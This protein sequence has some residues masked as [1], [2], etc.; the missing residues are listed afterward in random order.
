MSK[1]G[2]IKRVRNVIR[3]GW[4]VIRRAGRPSAALLTQPP[5]DPHG[6]RA[7]KGC[8]RMAAEMAAA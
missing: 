8:N 2:C 5:A 4:S 1:A 6:Q 7:G 3:H